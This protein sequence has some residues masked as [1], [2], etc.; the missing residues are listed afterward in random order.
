MD[1]IIR[2]SS[3]FVLEETPPQPT[4]LPSLHVLTDINF[5][6]PKGRLIGVCGSSKSGK[7]SLLLAIMGQL[8]HAG[9]HVAIDGTCAYVPEECSLFEGTL[10]ES[11]IIGETFDAALYYKTIQSCRLNEDLNSLPGNDDTDVSSVE[12]TNCQKQKIALARAIYNNRDIN[13]LDNPLRDLERVESS[14]IFE[15]G[16]VQLL[17]GKC[18]ILVSDKIQVCCIIFNN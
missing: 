18:V 13:L 11:I 9:G 12:F 17:G 14:E 7:S 5:Y 3:Q 4:N 1:K 10:K 15:K 16:I 6:A 8:K 2:S